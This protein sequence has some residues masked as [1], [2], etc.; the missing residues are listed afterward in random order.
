MQQELANFGERNTAPVNTGNLA[1]SGIAEADA[2]Y[3][4]D[5]RRQKTIHVLAT[6]ARDAFI[7]SQMAIDRG[8]ETTVQ[9]LTLLNVSATRAPKRKRLEE[10][11]E[12]RQKLNKRRTIQYEEGSSPSPDDTRPS[13]SPEVEGVEKEAIIEE[14][15]VPEEE[16]ADEEVDAVS[17]KHGGHILL[18]TGLNFYVENSTDPFELHFGPNAA[19]LTDSRRKVVEEKKWVIH[20]SNQGRLGGVV[21]YA[22]ESEVNKSQKTTSHVRLTARVTSA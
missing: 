8:S 12:P 1:G 21:A 19:V 4:C 18:L 5:C 9:L 15:E 22:P 2:H 10:G 20:K 13:A 16:L 17:G 3:L 14:D 6:A 11:A 7:L